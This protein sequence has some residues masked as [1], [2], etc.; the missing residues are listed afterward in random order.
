MPCLAPA[1]GNFS[2]LNSIWLRLSDA[3]DFTSQLMLG[4]RDKRILQI[5]L[6]EG[7]TKALARSIS[8]KVFEN[9]LSGVRNSSLNDL[10]TV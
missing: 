4:T 9:Y 5:F 2:M 8:N 10:F 6:V 3:R 1:I 7:L